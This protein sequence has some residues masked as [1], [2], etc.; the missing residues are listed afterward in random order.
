MGGLIFVSYKKGKKVELKWRHALRHPT[1]SKERWTRKAAEWNPGL[2]K[3]TNT[4]RTAGRPA[5]RWEDDLNDFVK[6]E[7]TET[8]KSNDLKNDTTWFKAA[9]NAD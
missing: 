1:Q 6:A 8:A 9:T 5:K 7:A 3:S 2:V 4:Q